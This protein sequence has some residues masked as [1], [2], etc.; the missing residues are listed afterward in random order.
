MMWQRDNM[1]NKWADRLWFIQRITCF[2]VSY[3]GNSI[4]SNVWPSNTGRT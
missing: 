1:T 3:W 2:G 4:R